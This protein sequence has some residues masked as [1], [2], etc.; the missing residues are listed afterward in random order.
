MGQL[1]RLKERARCESMDFPVVMRDCKR[2]KADDIQW[3]TTQH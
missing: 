1:E 2:R 3:E